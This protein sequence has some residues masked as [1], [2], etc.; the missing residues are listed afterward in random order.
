MVRRIAVILA[1]MA[2]VMLQSTI[3]SLWPWIGVKPDLI[4]AIVILAGLSYGSA[5]AAL[6]GFIGGFLLDYSTGRLLGA[7]AVSKMLVGGLSGWVADKVFGDHLLVPPSAV[8]VGTWLE[9]SVYLLLANA[10]GSGLPVINGFWAIVLPVGLVNVVFA[11]PVHYCLRVLE[12]I[13]GQGGSG[14]NG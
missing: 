6:M 4:T 1:M 5:P 8:L 13:P 14:G 3:C 10:F 12:R 9:Q 11:F 2:A 7:G